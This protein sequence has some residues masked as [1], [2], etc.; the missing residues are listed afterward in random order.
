MAEND[1]QNDDDFFLVHVRRYATGETIALTTDEMAGGMTFEDLADE[2]MEQT[3]FSQAAYRCDLKA[4]SLPTERQRLVELT[5][6]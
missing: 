6:T 4:P 3:P 1:E 5:G 2:E